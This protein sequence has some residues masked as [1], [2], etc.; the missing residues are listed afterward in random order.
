MIKGPIKIL[1]FPFSLLFGL[2][3]RVRNYLYNNEIL[4]SED[5]DLP[6]IVVGNLAVGGTGKTPHVE[7][8]ISLLSK[9]FKVAVLSRGYKRKTKGFV[10]ASN[11]STASDIGDEPAQI[12]SKFPELIVA[13]DANRASGIKKIRAKFPGVDV[14]LLDDAFQ[15]RRVQAGISILITD[16]NNRFTK[17][18]LMPF[19]RLREHRANSRRAH[20]ILVSRSPLDLSPIDRRIIVGEMPPL[21]HQH[22]YFSSVVYKEPL[23][24]FEDTP[25][26]LC[27][28]QIAETNRNVLLITGIASPQY[29]YDYIAIFSKKIV[30]LRYPDHHNF[31]E[32]DLDEMKREYDKLTPGNRCV[33]TTEKDAMRLKEI[34]NISDYLDKRVYYIPIGVTF[35]NNDSE[36]FNNFIINYVTK[37]KS[38]RLIS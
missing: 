36:E 18:F 8:L 33:I 22:L 29:F 14:I 3:V 35:L 32:K 11:Q 12:K 19:G 5:F 17:D 16:Y 24:F 23:P 21:D 4:K 7:Y 1:L 26:P 6:I 37:N 20:Y 10:L 30:H 25:E 15:H 27:L 28:G 2:I 13:T 31:S 9:K 38:N 34:S